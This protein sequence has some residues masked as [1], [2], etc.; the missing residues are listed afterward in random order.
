MVERSRRGKGQKKLLGNHQR[1]WL[2]GRRLVQETLAARHWPILEL[3]LANDLAPE[4]FDAARGAAD[5][6]GL[7]VHVVSPGEIERLCHTSEHQGYLAKMGPFPYRD[8]E[9]LLAAAPSCP[10]YLV[11][12][13]IQDPYNFGAILRSADVFGVAGVFVGDQRQAAVSSFAARSS[14]GA[15]NRVPLARVRDLP[16]FVQT[17]RSRGI[18]VVGA[19]EK[20]ALPLTDCDFQ[21]A[22]AVVIGNEGS[23]ISPSLLAC[24]DHMAQIPLSGQIG[25]LNAAVAAAVF[26]YEARRQRGGFQTP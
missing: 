4:E 22:T 11:L 21:P 17:L 13:A 18:V 19:S 6:L 8:A 24:C 14:A 5:R 7:K 15:V 1:C 12:D 20:A 25:S 16:Q 26:C 23:G 2:W 10:L 9:E 3:H